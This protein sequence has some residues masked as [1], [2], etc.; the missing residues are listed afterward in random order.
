MIINN[1][2]FR[3]PAEADSLILQ[4]DQGCPYN[5]CAFCG[6]YADL[7][8]RRRSLEQVRE[9]IE[10][11]ARQDPHVLRVFLADGDV[12]WRPFIE[13][14]VTL[15][16]LGRHFP[17]LA[18][19]NAYATGSSIAAKS[20]EE[21]REL[22]ALKLQTLYLGLESGDDETLRRVRKKEDAT[23]MVEAVRR[24]QACGL[25]LSVM[26]LLGL[27]GRVRT[28]EHAEATAAALNVMQPRL[29]SA[30]RV[31]PVPGTELYDDTRA[32]RFQQLTEQEVVAELE[33]IVERLELKN[34]VFRAD[35]RSNIVPL[36][37]RFP[38]GKELLLAQLETLLSSGT[39][40]SRSP[41]SM[42]LWL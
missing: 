2:M 41:G 1:P 10:T 40:D 27:G 38:R 16:E 12:L 39:L 25:R 3:P 17:E 42:P 15:V 7:K 31:I 37:G 35:H 19:V 29:L 23:T 6:M 36:E 20:D 32:G 18:R 26:I 9:M 28:R 14:R 24:A 4:V 30:L 13:L 33:R 34:T 11:E 8:Y 22:H 21:L 5:R